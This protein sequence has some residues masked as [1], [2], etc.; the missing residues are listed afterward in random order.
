L[1]EDHARL[2]EKL[3]EAQSSYARLHRAYTHALEQLQLLRHRLFVAKAERVPAHADQLAFDILFTQVQQ[4]QKAIEQAESNQDDAASEG[5]NDD[6]K[7]KKKKPKGRRDLSKTDLPERRIEILDPDLEGKVERIGFEESS[8]LGYERGGMRRIVVA[9]AVYRTTEPTEPIKASIPESEVTMEAKSEAMSEIHEAH[10][11]EQAAPSHAN[12]AADATPATKTRIIR[13][14]LPKE[15]FRR[16]LL[17][18]SMIAHLLTAKYMMGIPFYRLEQK[19]V[20]E[21]FSL[22]RGTMCR[23][24]EDAGATLGAIV[25]AMRKD[26]F[27][28]AFCLSTDATG[29]SIQLGPLAERGGQRKPCRKGHFFVVLADRDHVFFEYQAKHTGAVV[30]EMFKGFSRYIQADAHVIYDALFLG[31][32]PKGMPP[33]PSPGP[34]PIEVGCWSHAR[35]N[36][37]DAAVCKHEIGLEGLRRIDAI[38]AAD[39]LLADLAPS[40]RK[41]MRDVHVRPLVDAFFT[42]VKAEHARPRER[43]L[44]AKA[45]GYAI[46]QEQP[47]RRFLEDG[48][49]RLEN[50]ASERALRPI[51]TGRKAWLFF[52]SDDHAGA[53]AN[54]FSLVTSCKLHG[55]DPERY[56]DEVMRVM[57][58]WPRDRYLELS[59]RDWAATRARLDPIELERPLGHI[60]VPPPLPTQQQCTPS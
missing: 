37:W 26:A 43:G 15:L 57:P 55:L 36:F 12:N 58:Y 59:P 44:V 16:A 17:L 14:P 5:P 18:P 22:D 31:L 33:D 39:R 42:W 41:A 49:L 54:V 6:P 52:G 1:I 48:R 2:V 4:L 47:L 60:T 45:L 29:V 25:E 46:N 32:S 19:F 27:D 8:R 23:Y 30:C 11:A 40:Q 9:R 3:Q 50:N 53:A 35:R 24:A 21:G 34:P 56:L 38:F 10:S 13:A 51:A 28:H 20:L 7:K